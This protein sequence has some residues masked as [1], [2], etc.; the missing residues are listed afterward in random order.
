L[1]VVA[2]V[3]GIRRDFRPRLDRLTRGDRLVVL[4]QVRFEHVPLQ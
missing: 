2:V 1:I 3:D 4:L